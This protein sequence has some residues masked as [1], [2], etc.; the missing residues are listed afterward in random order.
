MLFLA[1]IVTLENRLGFMATLEMKI[2][3][4]VTNK[5]EIINKFVSGIYNNWQTF[6][7]DIRLNTEIGKS[8]TFSSINTQK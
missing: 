7:S 1:E 2:I 8:G 6:F 4:N 3:R 5:Q